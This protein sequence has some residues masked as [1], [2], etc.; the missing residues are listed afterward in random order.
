MKYTFNELK[1]ELKK[2]GLNLI[3]YISTKELISYDDIG[4]KYKINLCNIRNGRKPN[5]FM[6]NPYALDNIKL[7]LKNNCPNYKLLDDKYINCKTKMKFICNKHINKGIQ[8]N[9]VDNIVNSH[10]YCLYCGC[11]ELWE[12]KRTS[13]EKIKKECNRIGIKFIKRTSKNN[14][15][16]INYIC[17]NHREI[18]LQNIS[19]THL[20]ELENG[21]PHCHKMSKGES[22]IYKYLINNNIEFY[23]EYSFADC[24]KQRH[25]KFDYYVPSLNLVIEYNGIQHYKPIEHF[26][27]ISNFEKT[28]ERDNIKLQ[29]CEQNNIKVVIIPYWEYDNIENLLKQYIEKYNLLCEK[30]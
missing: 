20:K 30:V 15:C 13:V 1:T 6:K 24:I 14:E 29:Y 27:G 10:H 9:T 5:R 3:E 7:Y 21:C 28:K 22:R 25:L 12:R 23:R 18:G 16:Y 4:Y 26:G 19:W 2:Y 17:P 8:Y 11:S